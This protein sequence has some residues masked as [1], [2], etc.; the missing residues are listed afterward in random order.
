[1][2][3]HIFTLL[4]VLFSIGLFAEANIYTPTQSSPLNNS[5]DISPATLINWTAVPGAWS[6]KLQVSK[7]ST[8]ANPIEVI[9]GYSANTVGYLDYGSVY[10]WRVK[11]FGV[12]D[13]SD[14]SSRWAFT[15]IDIVTITSPLEGAINQF[16]SFKFGWTA[17]A[18]STGYEWEID[19]VVTYD[20]PY[21]ASGYVAPTPN[22]ANTAQL[23]FGQKYFLRVRSYHDF[24]TSGWSVPRMVTTID[25]LE[26]AF[27]TAVSDTMAPLID[28]KWKSI[29]ASRYEVALA[30]DAALTN[31]VTYI[32]D[33]S[34]AIQFPV[35]VH[36]HGLTPT[37]HFDSLYYWSVRA[38]NNVD[39]TA[40][41]T[42]RSFYTIGQVKLMAPADGGLVISTL[43]QFKWDSIFGLESYVLQYD[44][45][46]TFATPVELTF[47][48][49]T[50]TYT[51]V[52]A[53]APYTEY[54]W[55][56]KAVNTKNETV[57]ATRSFTT[58]S[59]LG[60][61][62]NIAKLNNINLYPNPNKGH[63]NVEIDAS[64]SSNVMLSLTNILGQVVLVDEMAVKAGKN[65]TS[66]N[67]NALTNGIY[68]LKIQNGTDVITRKVVLDK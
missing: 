61:D 26:L 32:V 38:M 45:D 10:Y 17:L 1:M 19:S 64:Q 25:T 33:S 46:P 48:D 23:H 7:D 51:P 4:M 44:T 5:V 58:G 3:K 43:P 8:F 35:I 28:I 20:S 34:T 55:R 13:S 50:V 57:W 31:P 30:F 53:L 11:A 54:F 68:M 40:W 65:T 21:Y 37:L 56:V 2:K 59:P 36:N 22:P 60:V 39:T 63:L 27:P 52:T 12:S 29:Y 41:M 18:G 9:T 62:E 49:D 24:D 42:P 66:M 14:W 67:L 47:G 6:Y 15:T 16:P